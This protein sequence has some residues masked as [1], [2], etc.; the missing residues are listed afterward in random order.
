MGVLASGFF[1]VALEGFL[2]LSIVFIGL[3]IYRVSTY[4]GTTPDLPLPS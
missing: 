4:Q 2:V 1:D 3:L